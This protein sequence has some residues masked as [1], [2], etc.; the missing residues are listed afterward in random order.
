MPAMLQNLIPWVQ[1]CVYIGVVA[2]ASDDNNSSTGLNFISSNLNAGFLRL[3]G[4][5]Q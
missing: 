5:A 3:L 4:D 2:L 1:I